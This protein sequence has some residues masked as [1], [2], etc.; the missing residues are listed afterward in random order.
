MRLPD[1]LAAWVSARDCEQQTPAHYASRAGHHRA[2]LRIVMRASLS[3]VFVPPEVLT[4]LLQ[5]REGLAGAGR[6]QISGS[7]AQLPTI[8]DVS[9]T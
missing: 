1:T 9:N 6:S 7:F 4:S 5:W 2:N 3:G 8:T